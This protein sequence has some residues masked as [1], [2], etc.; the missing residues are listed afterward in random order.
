MPN[1]HRELLELVNELPPLPLVATRVMVLTQDPCTSAEELARIVSTDQSLTA[2]LIRLSNSAAYA[3]GKPC[4]SARDAVQLLGFLQVRQVAITASLMSIFAGSPDED[5]MFD[6]DLFWGHSLTVA[7][8]AEALARATLAALPSDAFTAGILHDIGRLVIRQAMP[9]TFRTVGHV[10]LAEGIP[11]HEAE[12]RVTGYSHELVGEALARR[13]S[14]PE[15]LCEA[16]AHHHEATGA[17]GSSGLV[18]LVAH[19]NRLVTKAGITSGYQAES[20]G[21]EADPLSAEAV[22]LVGGMT[23]ILSRASWFMDETLG[24][25]EMTPDRLVG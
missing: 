13:W 2:K 23:T 16:I 12:E 6:S 1:D 3:F 14:F 17:P 22:R 20:S 25:R 9:D 4:A 15:P 7:I 21:D 18:G 11:F 10:A 19:A 5:I 24:R 8:A